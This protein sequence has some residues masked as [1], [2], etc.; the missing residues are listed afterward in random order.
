[1]T[2]IGN[3]QIQN[4]SLTVTGGAIIGIRGVVGVNEDGTGVAGNGGV[5]VAGNGGVGVAG[6]S[7][8]GYGGSFTGAAA[9]LL[10][11]PSSAAGPPNSGMH[12]MGE[13]YV[14]VNG[15][16]YFCTANGTPGTWKMVQLV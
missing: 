3:V 5:G 4:G 11:G 15:V 14:D 16:L 7:D 12:K 1:L 9:P 10:L 8:T 13:L 2:D 6:E